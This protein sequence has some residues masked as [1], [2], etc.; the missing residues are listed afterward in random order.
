MNP[1]GYYSNSGNVFSCINGISPG[2]LQFGGL[3]IDRQFNPEPHGSFVHLDV[4]EPYGYFF[5]A[6]NTCGKVH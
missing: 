2:V 1:F 4:C 3:L 5:F 6:Q